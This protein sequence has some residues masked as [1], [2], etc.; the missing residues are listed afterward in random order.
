MKRELLG[1]PQLQSP[2]LLS[3]IYIYIYMIC[4][5]NSLL[6]TLFLNVLELICLHTVKWF[7]VF[8][9]LII[10]FNINYLFANC[11]N[12]PVGWGCRIHWLHLC[13]GLRL[14]PNKCPGYDT[15][16]SDGEVPAVLELWG[17]WNTPSLLSLPG[18]LWLRVVAP[19]R[20]LSTG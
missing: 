3:Y 1:H 20:A 19:D 13:R 5:V 4:W 2:T 11:L 16:Q 17:I 12:C 9:T 6:L 14:P 7:Q 15:K 18:P 10:L 8:L